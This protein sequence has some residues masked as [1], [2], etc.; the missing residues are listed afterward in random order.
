MDLAENDRNLRET[1]N[2]EKSLKILYTKLN[3]CVDYAAVNPIIDGQVMHIAYSLVTEM[4]Q[5][6]ED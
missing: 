6:Q 5:F 3:E 1:L 4:G 2:P